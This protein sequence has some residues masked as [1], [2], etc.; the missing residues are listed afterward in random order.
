MSQIE[1]LTLEEVAQRLRKTPGQL[2][3][4]IHQKTAPVSAKIGGRR[5]FRASDVAS[6]VDAQFEAASERAAS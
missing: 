5:M 6:Y 2:R 4:M 3:W 1:L